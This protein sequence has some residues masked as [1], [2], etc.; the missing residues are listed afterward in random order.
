MLFFYHMKLQVFEEYLSR[1]LSWDQRDE[2][3]PAFAAENIKLHFWE[4]SFSTALII[5]QALQAL[6]QHQGGEQWRPVQFVKFH[7]CN[8]FIKHK[9]AANSNKS[10]V[11]I[12]NIV[13]KLL[14]NLFKMNQNYSPILTGK[15]LILEQPHL[16]DFR[17]FP[18]TIDFSWESRPV[19]QIISLQISELLVP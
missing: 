4:I 16:L 14:T 5:L 1:T 11:Q 15:S 18:I 9:S 19:L 3:S 10:N 17:H 7:I 12:L 8:I 13:I 2:S 6:Q